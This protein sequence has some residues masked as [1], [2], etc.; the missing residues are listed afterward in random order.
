M[1]QKE[2][3]FDKRAK[4]LVMVDQFSITEKMEFKLNYYSASFILSFLTLPSA[5][6]VLP[7]IAQPE[8]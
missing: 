5:F 4:L 1:E 3:V 8:P 7:C 2:K 6:R